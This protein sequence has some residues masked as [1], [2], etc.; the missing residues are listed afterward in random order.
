MQNAA[1]WLFPE[2]DQ[3]PLM[4]R[5]AGLLQGKLTA[6]LERGNPNVEARCDQAAA[7]AASEPAAPRC[8]SLSY[9]FKSGTRA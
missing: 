7:E 8:C 3:V 6:K 1:P 4:G 9:C 2:K 5:I